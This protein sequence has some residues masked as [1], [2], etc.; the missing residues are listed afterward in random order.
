MTSDTAL[1]TYYR[2]GSVSRWGDDSKRQ[3]VAALDRVR[4]GAALQC[5][6]RPR[7][8]LARGMT[9]RVPVRHVVIRR[10]S[11]AEEMEMQEGP[12]NTRTAGEQRGRECRRYGGGV[13]G[14]EEG[15]A[16]WLAI[17]RLLLWGAS[18]QLSIEKQDVGRG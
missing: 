4:P 2:F 17:G 5:T 7:L 18:R 3:E 8:R 15:R 12:E 6:T 10:G 11:S 1:D 14:G 13:L 16:T 9:G